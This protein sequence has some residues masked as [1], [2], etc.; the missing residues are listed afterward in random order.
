VAP[1]SA[2]CSRVVSFFHGGPCSRAQGKWRC[3]D[4]QA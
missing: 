1:F 2:W 3:K 4:E